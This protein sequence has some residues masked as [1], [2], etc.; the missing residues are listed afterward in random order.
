M[1]LSRECC[2]LGRDCTNP[3]THHSTTKA[4]SLVPEP[5]DQMRAGEYDATVHKE[6]VRAGLS[7]FIVAQISRLEPESSVAQLILVTFRIQSLFRS[8][9][10]QGCK[11][12]LTT[13]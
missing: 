5:V 7:Y 9:C 1:R 4:E 6:Q 10:S 3:P 2:M 11:S 13:C 12:N 8:S